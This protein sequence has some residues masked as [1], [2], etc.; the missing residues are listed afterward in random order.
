MDLLIENHTLI[1]RK[2]IEIA[3]EI[4]SLHDLYCQK[5]VKQAFFNLKI[6]TKV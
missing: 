3:S 5:L 4:I 6:N 1:K 2:K